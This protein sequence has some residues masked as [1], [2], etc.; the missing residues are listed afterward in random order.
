MKNILHISSSP[1]GEASN[2]ILLA[3]RV[4]SNLLEKYPESK[5]IHNDT[6]KKDYAHLDSVLQ[7]AYFTLPTDRTALQEEAIQDSEEAVAQLEDA[8]VIIISVAMYNF[9]IP[10]ALKAWIDHVVRAGKTFSYGNGKP[11]GL[12]S[13]NKKV[14]LAIASNG[15]FTEGPLKALDFTEPYLRFILSFIGL[16]DIT[17][18]RI[19]GAGMPDLKETA[20]EKGLQQVAVA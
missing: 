14:Y 9:S 10:S 6:V 1:R 4:I 13:S 20:V 5:V 3:N 19:E 18:Y 15:V 8:D 2:S 11:E 16:T 17:T 12:L 7:G